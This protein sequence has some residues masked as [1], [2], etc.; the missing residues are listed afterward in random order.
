MFITLQRPT[1]QELIL[2]SSIIRFS[3][4]ANMIKI[5]L[6]EIDLKNDSTWNYGITANRSL[7]IT[8]EAQPLAYKQIQEYLK[9][10]STL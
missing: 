5:T 9:S 4:F 7:E 1:H 8:Q 6:S 10:N 3:I 2:I